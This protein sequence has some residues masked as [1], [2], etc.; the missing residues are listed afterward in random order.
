MTGGPRPGGSPDGRIEDLELLDSRR[1]VITVRKLADSLAYGTDRSPFLGSGIEYV[2]SRPYQD[3]DSVRVMD[4]RVTARVGRHFVKEYE[5]PKSLPCWLLIDTSASMTVGS[6]PRTKYE[7]ALVLAGGLAL[8]CLDR[9]SPV[10]VIGVGDR[11]LRVRPSLSKNRILEWLFR[12]RAFRYDETTTLGA[13]L[14]EAIPSLSNR[15][16]VVVLSDLYDPDAVPALKRAAQRHD[17]V[18]LRLEDPSEERVRGAGFFRAREAET[19]REFVAF[20]RNRSLDRE[21]AGEALKRSGIDH[22]VVRTDRPFLPEVR[23]LFESRGFFA[24]QA[25]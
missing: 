9:V 14:R 1:F 19:G 7:T 11:P 18:V 8:A 6:T 4:W 17:V 13:R 25:R 24:R 15:A 5:V 2:Q 16:L 21:E 22:L 23:R 12:L 20:G 10:G 3:G